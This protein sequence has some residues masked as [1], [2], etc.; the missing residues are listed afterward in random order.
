MAGDR[1]SPH[2]PLPGGS[3]SF[4]DVE[5]RISVDT[6]LRTAQQNI[7]A[8]S[9]IADNKANIMIT[10]CSLVLSISLTQLDD[11]VLRW[12][13]G[14]LGLFSAAALVL[15]MYAALPSL[16]SAPR[17]RASFNPFFFGHLPHVAKAEYSDRMVA[18]LESDAVMY[19][20]MVSDLYEH[21]VGLAR[22]KYRSLRYSYL[23]FIAGVVVTLAVGLVVV[24]T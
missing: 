22:K 9:G 15:A 13:L 20:E 17:N 21:S 3:R 2:P 12:P 8:L 23:V 14:A 16:G 7:V 19:Q 4:D 24:V 5:P 10:V 18:T 6:V 11:E 1:S